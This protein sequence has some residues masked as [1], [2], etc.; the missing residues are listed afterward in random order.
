MTA[1]T[2]VSALVATV[3][4]LFVALPSA[5]Q[6][7]TDPTQPPNVSAAPLPG[8]V[9]VSPTTG[10]PVLQSIMHAPGRHAAMIDGREVRIGDKVGEARVVAIDADS[11]RLRE[12]S[13]T[14]VMRLTPDLRKSPTKLGSVEAKPDTKADAR[15]TNR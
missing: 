2:H 4:A 7:L 12:G 1:S 14:R 15:E 13:E 9:G 11:V 6:A 8:A 5:A 10:G 3:A